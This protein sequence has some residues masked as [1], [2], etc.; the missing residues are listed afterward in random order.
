MKNLNLAVIVSAAVLMVSGT[1]NAEDTYTK[2]V[3]NQ[4]LSKR[5]YHQ[6]VPDSVYQKANEFEGATLVRGELSDD[7]N[8]VNKHQQ[9]MRMNQLSKRPY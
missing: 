1:V 7:E 3:H 8:A 2:N 4:N 6:P 5:P 9:V